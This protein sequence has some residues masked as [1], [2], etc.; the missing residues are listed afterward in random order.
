MRFPTIAIYVAMF[1][2][3]GAAIVFFTG[4]GPGPLAPIE[5][6]AP[7]PPSEARVPPQLTFAPVFQPCAHCHEVGDRA[8]TSSGP[9]LNG[10]VGR[11]AGTRDDYPY[12]AAMKDSRIVWTQANLQRFLKG[13]GAVVPGTRMAVGGF[14]DEKIGPIIEFLRKNSSP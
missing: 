8:R 1:A 3:A 2:L 4:R 5:N 10:V 6:D 11:K 14:A 12:S 13:P 7:I 9:V